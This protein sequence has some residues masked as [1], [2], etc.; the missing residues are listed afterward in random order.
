M[1]KSVRSGFA[2]EEKMY[3]MILSILEGVKKPMKLEA[4]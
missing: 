4:L 1:S 2:F 3:E